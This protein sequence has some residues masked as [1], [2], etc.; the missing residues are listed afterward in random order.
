ML[1]IEC[2]LIQIP[3]SFLRINLSLLT[4]CSPQD[5]YKFYVLLMKWLNRRTTLMFVFHLRLILILLILLPHSALLSFNFLLPSENSLSHMLGSVG[6]WFSGASLVYYLC[7]SKFW[8]ASIYTR[9]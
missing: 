3:V 4:S 1:K 5:G 7:C 6:C 8:K 9:V 2:Y